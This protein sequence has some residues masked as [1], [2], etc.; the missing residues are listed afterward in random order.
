MK[1]IYPLS[2]CAIAVY[3]SACDQAGV[4]STYR[5]V[6]RPK[7]D[8]NQEAKRIPVKTDGAVSRADFMPTS[9]EGARV[10][11]IS[12]LNLNPSEGK[13][14][15]LEGLAERLD[16]ADLRVLL[17]AEM[18]PDEREAVG[19]GVYRRLNLLSPSSGLDLIRM[20]SPH[21][22][23]V[24]TDQLCSR[25]GQKWAFEYLKCRDLEFPALGDLNESMRDGFC[26]GA[27]TGF[28]RI[29]ITERILLLNNSLPDAVRGT[30]IESFKEGSGTN[31]V[32]LLTN[33]ASIRDD[34]VRLRVTSIAVRE[35]LN[36]EPAL[37]SQII[38]G[39]SDAALKS[40]AAKEIVKFSVKNGDINAARAWLRYI[41][42]AESKSELS[43]LIE[44][45]GVPK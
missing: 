25:V 29:P 34:D 15:K 45:A 35:S 1:R 24:A 42:D 7:P 30:M 4:E 2:S 43:T 27:A 21:L 31:Y 5:A 8:T 40:T 41:N 20:V 26:K 14:K 32:T 37:V 11:M 6:E 19:R 12:T 3:L 9:V 44:K 13:L 38:D 10:E 28:S 22:Q 33:L 18:F 17:S 16:D 39:E 36:N 23:P